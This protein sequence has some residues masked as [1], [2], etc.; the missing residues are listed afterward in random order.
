M[1]YTIVSWLG[2]DEQTVT[3]GPCLGEDSGLIDAVEWSS[4][5]EEF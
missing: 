3:F 4:S 1:L 2:N 5:S